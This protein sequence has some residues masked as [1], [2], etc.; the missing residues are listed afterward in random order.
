MGALFSQAASQTEIMGIKI[1]TTLASQQAS[2][3]DTS[4][5]YQWNM[6][7]STWEKDTRTIEYYDQQERV[8]AKLE[9]DWNTKRGWMN[10]KRVFNSY[11]NDKLQWLL[12]Q[13][14][15]DETQSWSNQTLKELGYKR[16]KK[17]NAYVYNWDS[18]GDRWIKYIHSR[19]HYSVGG[20]K[21]N[22]VTKTFSADTKRWVNQQKT[23]YY[24]QERKDVPAKSIIK[25]WDHTE[26][27]WHK[28]GRHVM[29]F[30]SFGDIVLE[31]LSTWSEVEN[32]WNNNIRFKYKWKNSNKTSEIK[33]IWDYM[34][35]Q[36]SNG[37][38][39]VFEYNEL[40]E[41]AQEKKYKWEAAQK[42]WELVSRT[43]YAPFSNQSPQLEHNSLPPL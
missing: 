3:I 32:T 10:S 28:N 9:Q 13:V 42:N 33:Q 43:M 39:T 17:T 1:D 29:E 11:N 31:T 5:N 14:W 12:T 16:N 23:E 38:K 8:K 2:M 20:L 37:T 7:S 25:Y 22:I 34:N 36:W 27:K 40:G 6:D 41:L 21:K 18:E 15:I 24:Y 35:N 4:Y 19:I 30:N 26:K